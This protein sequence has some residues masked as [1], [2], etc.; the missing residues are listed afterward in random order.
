MEEQSATFAVSY[1]ALRAAG[2]TCRVFSGTALAQD[3]FENEIVARA[4][5]PY[6]FWEAAMLSYN[7]RICPGSAK[8]SRIRMLRAFSIS[9][10]AVFRLPERSSQDA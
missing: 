5:R 6:F 7:F 4:N 3:A 10:I 2:I 1:T 9:G 8:L